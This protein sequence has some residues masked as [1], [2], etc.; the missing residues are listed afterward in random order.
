MLF[1]QRGFP[2]VWANSPLWSKNLVFNLA[3][4]DLTVCLQNA[5]KIGA[6]GGGVNT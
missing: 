5:S 3:W 6:E 4:L 1:H 2:C